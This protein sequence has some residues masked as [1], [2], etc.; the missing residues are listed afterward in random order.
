M[1]T[2][3]SYSLHDLLLFSAQ[4]W[5][6]LYAE[7]ISAW[8]WV[9]AITCFGLLASFISHR[10]KTSNVL[11]IQLTNLAL[12]FSCLAYYQLFYVHINGYASMFAICILLQILLLLVNVLRQRLTLRMNRG[13]EWTLFN[14]HSSNRV[15]RVA[16]WVALFLLCVFSVIL[17]HN[18]QD[19]ILM[20]PGSHPLISLLTLIL[21]SKIQG[22]HS[23][24]YY[25][26]PVFLVLVEILTFYVLNIHTWW[27]YLLVLLLVLL[28]TKRRT[29]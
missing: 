19:K 6:I 11:I 13:V 27:G 12:L 18:E 9:A 25:V 16:A 29:F 1:Q 28:P 26:L 8:W 23:T 20:I 17:Y 4:T 22:V 3:M 24:I 10:Y 15:H 14:H 7:Y 5:V 21:L 2:L